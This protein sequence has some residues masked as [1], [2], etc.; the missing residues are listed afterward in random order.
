MTYGYGGGMGFRGASP[1]WPYIGRGRGGLP[2]CWHSSL[3][4]GVTY[5][6][7]TSQWSIPT[8][9]EELGYL[10]N[11]ANSMK[12]QLEEIESRIKVLEEKK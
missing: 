10:K 7:Q 11:Q 4:R 8:S 2:R 12:H 1:E 5:P 3:Y 9:D 6:T